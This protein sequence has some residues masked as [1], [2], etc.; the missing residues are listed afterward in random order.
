MSPQLFGVLVI[1]AV[2]GVLV[3]EHSLLRS[4]GA[5]LRRRRRELEARRKRQESIRRMDRGEPPF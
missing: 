1:G 2:V 5:W 3:A 4:P